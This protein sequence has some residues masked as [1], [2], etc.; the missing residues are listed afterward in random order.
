MSR[1]ILFFVHGMGEHDHTWHERGLAVL[2]S[3]FLEYELLKQLDFDQLFDIVPIVY[4]DILKDTRDRANADFAAFKAATLGSIPVTEAAS[5]NAVESELSKYQNLIGAGDDNFIW[6][7]ILDVI[8]YRF[9][10]TIRMGI[11]VSVAEQIVAAISARSHTTW[12]ILAHSLGTSVTHN[13]LNSLYNTGFPASPVGPINPLDPIE[14]RCNSLI[15]IANVSRILQRPG[16]KVYESRVMPGSAVNGRLCSYYLN[17]RHKLDPF[18]APKPFI[19]DLWPDSA[20]FSS[21]RYQHITPSHIH[22]ED[23]ELPRVHDL[24]HYLTNPRVHVPMFRSILG[25]NIISSQ[26]YDSARSRFDS[27]NRSKTIEHARSLLENRLPA[28]TGNWRNLLAAIK[29]LYS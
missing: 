20:T 6:T 23:D 28:S 2:K 25:K 5:K 19:P 15:M 18:V 16:A 26:E 8:L 22:F 14:S 17:V 29:R 1:H 7:H 4:N 12:S 24:D 21:K 3:V 27:E 10:N 11:D 13:T 9:S